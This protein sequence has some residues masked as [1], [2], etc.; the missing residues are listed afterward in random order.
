MFYNINRK[1][2]AV[3]ED[4]GDTPSKAGCDRLK[5][6]LLSDK[7]SSASRIQ[8]V[9]K[10][11]FYCMILNYMEVDPN[12]IRLDISCDAEGRYILK[13]EARANRIYNI[14]FPPVD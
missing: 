3:P 12:A 8:G 2:K 9:I 7:H 10:S 5:N 14:N 1:T 11:D 4:Y 13:L 6:V